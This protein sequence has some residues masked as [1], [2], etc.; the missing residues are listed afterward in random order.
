MSCDNQSANIRLI[1]PP[2][3]RCATPRGGGLMP[4]AF[5]SNL[6]CSMPSPRLRCDEPVEAGSLRY[7]ATGPHSLS[8]TESAYRNERSLRGTAPIEARSLSQ[9]KCA[10]CAV[11]AR[12]TLPPS[13]RSD[14]PRWTFRI[15]YQRFIPYPFLHASKKPLAKR[16]QLLHIFL[17]TA[18]HHHL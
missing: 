2:P 17:A 5:L 16:F 18:D 4:R 7:S 11:L 3:A 8:S 14:I 9:S 1:H 13:C 10:C 12:A 6:N 15:K